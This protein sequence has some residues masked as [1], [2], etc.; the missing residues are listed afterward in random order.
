MTILLTGPHPRHSPEQTLGPP[1]RDARQTGVCVC[2]GGGEAQDKGRYG[3]EEES[4]V[5]RKGY[6]DTR[7]TQAA[8]VCVCVWGGG[9][10]EEGISRQLQ[11]GGQR[12][13]FLNDPYL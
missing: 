3:K 10:E 12:D 1:T 4:G 2:G 11:Q 9:G 5:R 13:Q 7:Q 8:C 6:R